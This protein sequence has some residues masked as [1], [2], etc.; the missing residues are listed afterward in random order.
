MNGQRLVVLFDSGSAQDIVS[1]SLVKRARLETQSR[2]PIPVSGFAPG[3]DSSITEECPDVRV[4]I[5]QISF[6]R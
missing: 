2:T 6:R 5:Q 3:M 1:D 4:Q